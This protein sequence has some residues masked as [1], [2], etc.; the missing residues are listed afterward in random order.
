M[1]SVQVEEHAVNGLKM[2]GHY[3]ET[4]LPLQMEMASG[5]NKKKERKRK[6]CGRELVKWMSSSGNEICDVVS[7]LDLG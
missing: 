7:N 3:I 5:S 6:E 1:V 2:P 4:S